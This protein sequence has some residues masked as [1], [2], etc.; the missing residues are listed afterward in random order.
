MEKSFLEK[1]QKKIQY[2]FKE[3]KLLLQAMTHASA[4]KKNNERLEFLGDSVLNYIIS[5]EIYKKFPKVDEGNMSRMR[6]ILV[7]R[8][9]LVKIAKKIQ[10]GECLS[11][12]KGERKN[13]GY[14]RESILANTIE[15]LIGSI[16]LD[17]SIYQ[18]EKV[19]LKF[20]R[21][22]L[23]S[24]LYKNTDK[25]PKTILQEY[26]Q[27]KHLPLPIY[28]VKK[29]LGKA[30]KQKFIIFCY[31]EGLSKISVGN[32]KSRRIAEQKAAKKALHILGIN[33]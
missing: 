13:R 31:I 5:K 9:T 26:L 1:L 22:Y 6:A 27:K 29:I 33:I 10:I 15:A 24:I 18:T 23:S 7:Q 12:G 28:S 19:V 17:S 21:R 4:G 8:K 14:L 20:Y 32:G 25:D 3:K 11:L 2:F 30:H 16:F